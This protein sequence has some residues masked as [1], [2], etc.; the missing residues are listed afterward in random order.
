M[1]T[2]EVN[3]RPDEILLKIIS[4]MNQSEKILMPYLMLLQL[5]ENQK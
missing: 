2:I 5:T 4:R 1:Q 3:I